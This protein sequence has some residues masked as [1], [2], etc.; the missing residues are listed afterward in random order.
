MA[1][2]QWTMRTFTGLAILALAM[3]SALPAVAQQVEI[4][5]KRSAPEREARVVPPPLHYETTRP[6][7][8]DV[9]FPPGTRVEHDPAFFEPAAKTYQTA[10]SS[11]RYGLS[12][13][14]SPNPPV[15]AAATNHKEINGWLS[16]GFSV[17]WDGPAPAPRTA[18]PPPR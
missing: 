8:A 4:E 10:T 16:F 9:Y 18:P 11:G 2:V 1:G 7:D 13:W 12:G 17:T 3:S 14:T 6:P 5:A 15:G